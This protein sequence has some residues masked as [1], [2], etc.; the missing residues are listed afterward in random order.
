MWHTYF[1]ALFLPS[2]TIRWICAL[3]MCTIF[4]ADVYKSTM[5]KCS[6]WSDY[7]NVNLSVICM[8]PTASFE[9]ITLK[10]IK[11][12][13]AD[14]KL[15]ITDTSR[16][17]SD[18][19]HIVSRFDYCKLAAGSIIQPIFMLIYQSLLRLE[20]SNIPK[21][22]PIKLVSFTLNLAFRIIYVILSHHYHVPFRVVTL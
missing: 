18:A 19:L 22:C 8:G 12:L 9:F 17:H 21:E 20:N 3:L 10:S 6:S 13:E 11:R 5:N 1:G 2:W 16:P 15:T 4:Q 7:I 14:L